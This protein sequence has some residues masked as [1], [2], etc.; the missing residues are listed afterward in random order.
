Y[1]CIPLPLIDQ[2][3]ADTELET[4]LFHIFVVGIEML[5][6]QHTGRNMDGVALILVIALAA[7]FRVSIAFQGVKIGFGMCV[8]VALGMR[9]VN[10]DRADRHASSLETSLLAASTH[11]KIGRAMFR[12]IGLFVLFLVHRDA[13]AGV[14]PGLL[15]LFWVLVR[16][17]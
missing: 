6:V 8:A 15:V 14:L 12:F 10:E 3:I 17:F 2:L 1:R 9:Q 7:D 13:L 5:M 4:Q 16:D 11:E